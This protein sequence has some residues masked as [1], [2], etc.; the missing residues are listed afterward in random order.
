MGGSLGYPF[1]PMLPSLVLWTVGPP[2][3]PLGTPFTP[4]STPFMSAIYKTKIINKCT[5]YTSNNSY[6]N[7]EYLFF[8]FFP[9]FIILI[10]DENKNEFT[11]I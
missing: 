4:F 6:I 8:L 5:A 11:E 2:D 7:L 1:G 9:I 3:V 10:K